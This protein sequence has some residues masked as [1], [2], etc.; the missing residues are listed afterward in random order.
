MHGYEASKDDLTKRL[1]RIEGQVRGLQRMIDDD[2]YCIDVVTQVSSVTSALRSVALTLMDQHLSHCVS[3][4]AA[5]G[6]AVAT[7]KVSEA[8]AAI[9]RL[10]RS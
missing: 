4:A 2:A 5:Q 8:S 10:V 1:R 7:E 6:G 9:A 3:E